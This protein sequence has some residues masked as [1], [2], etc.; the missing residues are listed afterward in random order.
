[1]LLVTWDAAVVHWL[2]FG[3]SADA[4]REL[5]ESTEIFLSIPLVPSSASTNFDRDGELGIKPTPRGGGLRNHLGRLRQTLARW[6][7][8]KT[9]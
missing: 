9:V 4:E 7:S 6:T 2:T 3:S 5:S 1:M 8:R